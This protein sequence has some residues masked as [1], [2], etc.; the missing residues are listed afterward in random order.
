[1]VID[2]KS[3]GLEPE[4]L[5]EEVVRGW[6]GKAVYTSENHRYLKMLK[7]QTGAEIYTTYSILPVNVTGPAVEAG[8][9]GVAIRFDLAAEKGVVR[10][11]RE[12]G[13]GVIVW[14]V[15]TV[16]Q[17]EKVRGLGVNG[18]VSDR[19]DIILKDLRGKE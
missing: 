13:L 8:A 12:A 10:A 7:N 9:D 6:P 5:V 16:D 4:R 2:V 3:A 18:V 11:L 17:L 1:M 19:P 15:N 14:T